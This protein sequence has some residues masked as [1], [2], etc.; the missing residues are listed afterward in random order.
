MNAVTPGVISTFQ[1]GKNWLERLNT[2]V[3]DLCIFLLRKETY[4]E[5]FTHISS[6]G[7]ISH[8]QFYSEKESKNGDNFSFITSMI[9]EG[10]GKGF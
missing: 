3:M 9:K 5:T 2:F 8:D 7:Y 6:A 10:E 4:S 1:A